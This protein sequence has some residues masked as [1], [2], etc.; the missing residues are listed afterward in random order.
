MT[1]ERPLRFAIIGA[2]M[3]GILSAIKLQEAGFDDFTIYEKADRLG[4]TWRENTYPGIACDVP[5]PPLQ[6]LVRAQPE[7]SHRFSPG[8]EIQAYFEGVARQHGVDGPHPLRRGGHALRVRATAAGSSRRERPAR[9]GRRRDRG[10]RRAPPP[11]PARHRGARPLRGRAASTARAGTT[12]SRSTAGASA[13][14]APARPR[15][16][17]SRRSSTAWRSSRSSSA[18]RSGSCRRRTRP[19]ARRRRRRSAA[20]RSA[21]RAAARRAVAAVRAGLLATRSSTPSSPQM[22]LIEDAC[23]A[24]LENNVRDPVLREKLRPSYRAAC[25]RLV[26]SPDFYE[27]IQ[28]PNAELVTEGIERVEARRRA[29]ARRAAARA[30]RAGARHRLPG[31]PL[32]APDGGDRPRRPARSTSVWA[33]RPDRL[34]VD[35]DSRLPEPLHA[36]R[37]Q[38]SGRQLLAD[39]G[40]RAAD[41]RTSCS[42][43]SCC[44]PAAAARSAPSRGG[45]R[46]LRGRRAARRRSKTVWITGCRSWYLDD[47]GIP[48]VWPWTFDRFREEMAAP[49]ARGLGAGLRR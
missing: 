34:P 27:A 44:A 15:C 14:S 32:H 49:E 10:D 29:H 13:S 16:R 35:L 18:P 33:K 25:K 47:R 12:T 7:W 40:R 17:S 4:G 38:R 2:G 46:A 23:R 45:D 30:R 9:R 11:E 37:P 41:R 24:N 31:R 39:R 43:S 36:E 20:T 28:K 22:K 42:S 26:I 21:M 48:A 1:G 19:T 5:S 8:A 6:L 3:A